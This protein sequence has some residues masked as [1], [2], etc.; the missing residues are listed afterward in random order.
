[1]YKRQTYKMNT[2]VKMIGLTVRNICVTVD[3]WYVQLV[4][5]PNAKYYQRFTGLPGRKEKCLRF[6]T[7]IMFDRV[8]LLNLKI[9]FSVSRTSIYLFVVFSFWY[10][11]FTATY[12]FI[13]LIFP[14]MSLLPSF[15]MNK[16]IYSCQS[17]HKYRWVPY[18]YSLHI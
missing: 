2:D 17:F 4:K 8:V 14:V 6:Q 15:R 11:Q 5:T 9:L 13:G 1:M 10:C 18:P 3:H 7:F 16:L 12:V